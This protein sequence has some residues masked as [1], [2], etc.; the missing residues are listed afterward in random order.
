MALKY[1]FKTQPYKYQL[2]AL[3]KINKLDGVAGLF[4]EMGTGKTKVAID[5]AGIGYYN[6]D[7]KRVLVICPL[8]VVGVWQRQIRQ[9]LPFFSRVRVLEGSTVVRA[10]LIRKMIR[11]K[12]PTQDWLIINYEGIWRGNGRNDIEDLLERWGPDLI[13]CDEAHRL[14]SPTARQSKAAARLGRAARQRLIL[15]GTPIT[16]SPLDV[17]G[18]F[19][20]L[21]DEVF[22]K[23]WFK[24]K[25][26]Y[27][28]WGGF[29]RYQVIGYKHLDDLIKKI[30]S[31]TFRI[32][33][34]KALDLPEKVFV[35]V[36]VQLGQKAMQFYEKMAK[37]MIIEIEETHATAA[38]VLVK[39]LR[40]SQITSGFIKDVEGGIRVFDDSKLKAC[41][42]LLE[43][44]IAQDQK[45]VIFVRF[46]S[47][48]SR[49]QES[50]ASR[51]KTNPLIL[52]GSVPHSKRDSLVQRFQ[53]DAKAKVFIAQ[54]QAGSLGIDLTAASVAIF[55]SLDYNAANYWQAQDR[56][57]RHG[58]TR[59]VT[60]YHLVVPRTI[61]TLTLQILKE[62]GNIA[63]AIVHDPEV[64]RP[65]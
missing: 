24:F 14:K 46:K 3:A 63:E 54:I 11:S 52:S 45:V 25:N 9:H 49:L 42:D 13:I 18:Q 1:K 60:Y 39:I 47:D 62:K 4:M 10:G 19:R 21:D 29:G 8:S 23:N 22:G 31:N 2:R 55:Y 40:L 65:K 44:M 32:K 43:D 30:R 7:I 16:K 41:L 28:V 33:K 37:E 38:I 61:D 59:K 6:Y 5:W 56:I 27:G 51:L 58:Q 48:I 20:F 35:T 26:H 12:P 64:L 57:H 36:P 17:F 34:E 15:T 50:I 53:N